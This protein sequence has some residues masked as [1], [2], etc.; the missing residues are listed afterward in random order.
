MLKHSDV[1][2]LNENVQRLSLGHDPVIP[3]NLLFQHEK[4]L[5]FATLGMKYA[6][7]VTT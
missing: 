4:V 2:F 3:F 5:L 1:L 7:C 6:V